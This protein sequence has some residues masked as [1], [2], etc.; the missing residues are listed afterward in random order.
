VLK[1]NRIDE[2]IRK[3]GVPVKRLNVGLSESYLFF[4]IGGEPYYIK[5]S[6]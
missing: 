3:I 6:V 2:F 1:E 4:E 5:L